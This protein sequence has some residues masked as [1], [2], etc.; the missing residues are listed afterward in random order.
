MITAADAL[1]F[2]SLK[3]PGALLSVISVIR[4]ASVIITFLC[5]AVF[6]KEGNLK[7]KSFNLLLMAAG[8]VMLLIF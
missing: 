3:Q 1:Y 8:V 2:F 5:G 4:R 7:A 6:F